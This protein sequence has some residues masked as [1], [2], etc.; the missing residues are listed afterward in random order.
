[1]GYLGHSASVDCTLRHGADILHDLIGSR[2]TA[3]FG[4]QHGFNT[5]AQ[6][7]M[8]ESPHDIHPVYGIPVF[9]LYSETREPTREML[10]HIDTLVI[11]LNDIGVRVYTY[12]WT[13][14]LAMRACHKAGV[15][16]VILDRPNPLDGVTLEGN[17]LEPAFTS[18]VGLHPLPMRHGMTIGEVARYA[19]RFWGAGEEPVVISCSGWDRTQPFPATG[20]PWVFPSPNL[21][22]TDTLNI[23][24]GFVLFE[25]T[26]LSEGRG[27]VRPFELFGHPSIKANAWCGS[28]NAAL[29][30]ASLGAFR[31][32]PHLFVP[33]FEKWQGTACYGYQ[34]HRMGQMTSGSW[35]AAQVIMRELYRLM[36]EDFGWRPPPFEYE[37]DAMPIDILNGT[38]AVRAWIERN[39][40]IQELAEIEHRGWTA[41]Q[42]QR[43][44]VLLPSKS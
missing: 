16:V 30:E 19:A 37:N 21:A 8:I 17:L 26:T 39:G 31:V 6:D 44:G 13:M 4:P 36:G 18:F 10:T 9:S 5:D 27:T 20:L 32:R 14:V 43:A 22:T 23:Y 1:M 15:K 7:N 2:L 42:E 29:H 3:L 25:G 12:I 41:F 28:I 35:R 38:D 11:D 24:P 33:T 40:S 34:I